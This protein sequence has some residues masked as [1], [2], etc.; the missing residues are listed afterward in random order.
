MILFHCRLT[1]YFADLLC[2]NDKLLVYAGAERFRGSINS[3]TDCELVADLGPLTAPEQAPTKDSRELS[4]DQQALARSVDLATAEPSSPIAQPWSIEGSRGDPEALLQHANGAGLSENLGTNASPG[5]T[6][7][8]AATDERI[9][10]TSVPSDATPAQGEPSTDLS[11]V[12]PATQSK[13]TPRPKRFQRA[14]QRLIIA[15]HLAGKVSLLCA[16][17]SE[18]TLL[19]AL[20]RSLCSR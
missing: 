15:N 6:T 16:T 14:V 20:S 4:Q 18:L 1:A 10:P 2:T 5:L 11:A 3:H 7:P 12:T 8:P 17:V 9:A 19:G 13:P